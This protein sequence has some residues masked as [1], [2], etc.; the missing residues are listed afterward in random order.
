MLVRVQGGLYD[1]SVPVIFICF[2][3]VGAFF[4]NRCLC[5]CIGRYSHVCFSCHTT[6]KRGGGGQRLYFFP[7]PRRRR[8]RIKNVHENCSSDD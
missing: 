5:V 8:R 7:F 3:F 4:F 1:S 2:F 6:M